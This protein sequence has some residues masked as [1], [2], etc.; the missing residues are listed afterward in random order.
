MFSSCS[1]V[2]GQEGK[3]VGRETAQRSDT[4]NASVLQEEEA[5]RWLPKETGISA[6]PGKKNVSTR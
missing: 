3:P 1:A 6:V 5:Q 2:E 4:Q